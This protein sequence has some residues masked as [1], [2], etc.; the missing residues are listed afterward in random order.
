MNNPSVLQQEKYT[1]F[2]G[3]HMAFGLHYQ[4][5][6]DL[7]RNSVRGYEAL[8]RAEFPESQNVNTIELMTLAGAWPSL[9]PSQLV[10]VGIAQRNITSEQTIAL[11]LSPNYLYDHNYNF[12]TIFRELA[13]KNLF[14]PSQLEIELTEEFTTLDFCE[15]NSVISE[16]N[17]FG[18]K[19]VI[20]D[21]GVGSWNL[22]HLHRLKVQG[23]KID[24]S[25]VNNLG[26]KEV[27]KIIIDSLVKIARSQ[28]SFVIA[29]GVETKTQNS[30]VKELGCDFAQG[31]FHGRPESTI[32]T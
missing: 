11:N 13:S 15:V 23:I 4:R 14:N 8:F 19:V 9:W 28:N 25:F 6:I 10:C 21:F 29:E 26:K 30:L 5:Q 2:F 1:D 16:L 12:M 17:K 22:D 27:N 24:K 18:T 20:D 31:W 3:E 32:I 7:N